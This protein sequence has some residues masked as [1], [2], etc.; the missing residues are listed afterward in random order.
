MK[1]KSKIITFLVLTVFGSVAIILLYHLSENITHYHNTFIRRFPQH[2]AQ[3]IQ[4]TDLK[5][6][7]YYFA[8]QSNGKI[9]LGNY[10]A[11][12]QVMVIDS[13][14]KTNKVFHIVLKQQ[15]LPI[16]SPQIRVL[17][18]NFYVFEGIAPYIFKGNTKDWKATL[19]I[20][21]GQYFSQLEPIDSVNLAIRYMQP[22]TG[23]S[24][25][26]NINLA[27]TTK[28]KYNGSLLQ[29]QFDGI[30]D[31]DG[32][33]MVNHNLNKIIY[34]YLYRN[35]FIVAY[36]NLNLEYRANTI[37]TITHAQI[38]LAKL[39]DGR[40]KTFAK[41]PLIVNKVTAVDNNL[42]FVNSAL[43]GLYETEELWKTASIIDV[44]NLNDKT[45]RSSFP[46]YDI[47]KHKMR[48][49]IVSGKFLYALI[50]DKIVCYK[51]LEHLTQTR[52]AKEYSKTKKQ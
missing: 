1:L 48:S 30:F 16:H 40:G 43:S 41:P 39:K 42:L 11:P 31:T 49:M 12:L 6:N 29:K 14:L 17:G 7:S 28:V 19:R 21:S 33:L 23:Q 46:V 5:F 13:A 50:G 8:G 44:Y 47:G 45:Y 51:L 25:I 20:S 22:K 18:S 24:I 32:S 10:T 3:Q 15:H 52:S 9:Y 26:G 27:D 2:T 35:Q 38:K 4:S 37:D 34:V 36:P